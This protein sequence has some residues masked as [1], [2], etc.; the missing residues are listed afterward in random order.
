[1]CSRL[2]RILIFLLL[3]GAV[4]A[5]ARQLPAGTV[6]PVMLNTTLNSVKSKVGDRISGKL[7][8]Q[9]ELPSGERIPAGARVH[10]IVTAVRS[11][12]AG[13]PNLL[14]VRFERLVSGTTQ[15][16]LTTKL[17]AL[18][19]ML[20]VFDAQLPVGTFDD[21]GTSTSDWTTVQIGGAAVYHGDGTVRH[22][23]DI[24][25]RT[26]ELGEAVGKLQPDASRGCPP[27]PEFDARPQALWLFS[28]WACGTYGLDDLS[29]IRDE[30]A[31]PADA[32]A[33][34]SVRRIEIRAGSGWLLLTETP[35]AQ[36]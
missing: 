17:R 8:Q 16:A 14:E 34:T 11:G 9:V 19:S 15:Y 22:A 12:A 31:G 32:I 27:Q 24:I 33:L 29:I 23:M 28:P 18:A 13:S 2:V 26:T 1:M 7:M 30:A 6:L 10:G 21:Y 4:A 25:G 35:R 36:K 5:T 3:L 20:E